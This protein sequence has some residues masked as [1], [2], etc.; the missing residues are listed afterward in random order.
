MV[1][2]FVCFVIIGGVCKIMKL[3][4]HE[5]QLTLITKLIKAMVGMRDRNKPLAH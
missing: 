5:L 1:E 2:P 3:Q 4:E